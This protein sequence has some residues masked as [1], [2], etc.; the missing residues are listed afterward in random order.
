MRTRRRGYRLD[1]VM[2]VKRQLAR[3]GIAVHSNDQELVAE[4]RAQG[5]RDSV[6]LSGEVPPFDRYQFRMPG[7][8]QAGNPEYQVIQPPT[9]D[10]EH[11]KKRRRPRDSRP[12]RR[13]S[14]L[15]DRTPSAAARPSTARPSSPASP[16]DG[17]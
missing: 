17:G 6:D 12:G 2:R 8:A 11:D 4:L 9:I 3:N 13:R 10:Q 16:R 1:L 14:P 7:I 5:V 15:Q